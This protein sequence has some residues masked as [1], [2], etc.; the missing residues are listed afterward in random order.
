MRDR[1]ST[2]GLVWRL[3]AAA[4]VLSGCGSDGGGASDGSGAGGASGQRGPHDARGGALG[5]LAP[6]GA[7]RWSHRVGG[8]QGDVGRAI[9]A[10]SQGNVFVVGTFEG[11]AEVGGVPMTG[12]GML[13]V[14]VAK[15]TASGTPAWVRHYGGAGI[16]L[17]S[18]VAVDAAGSVWF[19]GTSSAEIDLGGGVLSSASGAGIYVAKLD[20]FGNYVTARAFGGSAVGTSTLVALDA[21][22]DLVIAGTYQ[23]AIDVGA[24]PLPAAVGTFDAFLAKLDPAGTLV[25]AERLG[26]T[27]VDAMQSLAL[28]ANGDIVLAGAFTGTA[29]FGAGP[30]VSAGD[31]DMFVARY[32]AA[33]KARWTKRY[34]GVDADIARSVA[35]DGKGDVLFSGSFAGAVDLGGGKL[36]SAGSADAFIAKLSASGLYVWVKSFG[37]VGRDEAMSIATDSAHHVLVAGFFEDAMTI[38][39]TPF[40]STGDRD[41]FALKLGSGGDTLF[42]KH[43]GSKEDDEASAIASDGYGRVLVTGYFRSEIDFGDGSHTSAGEDDVFLATFEP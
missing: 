6:T 16:D 15:F 32:D 3:G 36:T 39:T 27:G 30:L 21:A 24:G 4:L 5:Q 31:L 28:D 7:T 43:F 37:G 26:G 41:S 18:G 9:A 1:R 20:A 38:G 29:D 13:D 42:A 12:A 8:S 34:G 11:T 25:F 10:D 35:V 14:F 19:S 33:G 40:Q 22:G 17:V 23:T 2:W